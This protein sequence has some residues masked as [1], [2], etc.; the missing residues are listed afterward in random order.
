MGHTPMGPHTTRVNAS[1]R[2]AW[3]GVGSARRSHGGLLSFT[4]FITYCLFTTIVIDCYCVA[5]YSAGLCG[6]EK[7]GEGAAGGGGREVTPS[8]LPLPVALPSLPVRRE[9]RQLTRTTADL[10]RLVPMIVILVGLAGGLRRVVWQ[11]AGCAR[12]HERRLSSSSS[13]TPTCFCFRA[14]ISSQSSTSHA[15][16]ATPSRRHRPSVAPVSLL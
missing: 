2:L 4:T 10:F 12:G 14:L 6:V 1:S 9:R 5:G 7:R 16:G 8:A 13:L 11:R 15:G 3:E